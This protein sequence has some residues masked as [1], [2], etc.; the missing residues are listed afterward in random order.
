MQKHTR[1]PVQGF[2]LYRLNLAVISTCWQLTKNVLRVA[3]ADVLRLNGFQANVEALVRMG[4]RACR[5][6]IN[7]CLCIPAY[8]A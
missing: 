7:P 5:N 1:N 4:K 6:K 2:L 8:G 3:K